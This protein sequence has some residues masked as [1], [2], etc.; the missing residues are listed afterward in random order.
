MCI[1]LERNQIGW[2]R[3]LDIIVLEAEVK[4]Q[5][6]FMIGGLKLQDGCLSQDFF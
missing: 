1:I 2:R 6:Y 4:L 3:W 5:K